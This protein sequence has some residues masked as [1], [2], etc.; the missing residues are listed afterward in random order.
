MLSLK[1]IAGMFPVGAV[2]GVRRLGGG[3]TNDTFLVSAGRGMF[4]LQRLHGAFRPEVLADTEAVT[5]RLALHGMRTP[6]LVRTTADTLGYVSGRECW[7]MLTFV[8]GRCYQEALSSG[9]VRSSAELLGRFHRNLDGMEYRFAHRLAHFHDTEHVMRTLERT[10][11]G[12]RRDAVYAQMEPLASAVLAGYEQV[13]GQCAGA[14]ERI[15]HGDPK[16]ANVRFDQTGQRAVALLD[17]DT[18]GRNTVA[19]ELGDAARSWCNRAAEGDWRKARF[20]LNNFR[21]L[22]AGYVRGA[23]GA[24]DRSELDSVPHGVRTICLEL[25][26]RFITDAFRREYFK[27]DVRRYRDLGEQNAARA[28]SQVRL[29]RDLMAKHDAVER[30]VRSA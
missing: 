17:L 10:L 29:Y 30:I 14:P 7:R 19:V 18:V 15:I 20:D 21:A 26:A 16:A 9:Q 25:A 11:R 12:R 24:V 2:S 1:R 4:V 27:L 5:A 28:R 8:P 6:R 23:D 22:V 13:R 3:I